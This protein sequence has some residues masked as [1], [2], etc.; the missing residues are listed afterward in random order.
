MG[1][2][3]ELTREDRT[4]LKPKYVYT[5]LKYGDILGGPPDSFLGA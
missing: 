2:I 3:N 5:N 1:H 4:S